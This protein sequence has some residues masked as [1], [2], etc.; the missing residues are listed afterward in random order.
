[1]VKAVGNLPERKF[2]KE[3]NGKKTLFCWPQQQDK[4]Y[5]KTL[6]GKCFLNNS[7]FETTEPFRWNVP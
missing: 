1:M 7:F 3:F 2:S 5:H 4:V 6:Q